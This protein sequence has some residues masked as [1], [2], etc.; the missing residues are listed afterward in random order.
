MTRLGLS[1]LALGVL[2]GLTPAAHA[3]TFVLDA[4]T[5]ADYDAVGDGWFF[6]SPPGLPPDGVG[7]LGGNNL[8]VAYQAGVVEL[9]AMAEFP[10][11][12]VS[13]FTALQIVSATL[14]VTIDDIIGTFGPGTA[15]DG[16][17]GNPLVAFHYPADG[18]VTVSDFSPPGLTEVGQIVT[19]TITDASLAVSGALS[20]DVDVTDELKDA[21]TNGDAAFGALIATLDTPTATSLDNLGVT[22]AQLPILTIETIPTVPPAYDADELACQAALSKETAKL[23]AAANKALAGCLDAVLKEAAKTGGTIGAGTV[24]KCE[25]G[26][27]PSDPNA[28]L[29]KAATKFTST[30]TGKCTGLVPA[31]IGSPC[32][33]GAASIADTITCARDIALENANELIGSIYGNACTLLF[34][35][36]LDD[37]YPGVCAP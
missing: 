11:A 37:D 31:D 13:G 10:L 7:D 23:A 8:A 36:G 12:P 16:T 27:D 5:G 15:F 33:A 24:D 20:F 22:G 28:K 4:S 25:K 34:S 1:S 32:D 26:L 21:L 29:P 3:I 19:G 30:V 2:L 17:A 35:V 14:T 18:T 6:T 9:R